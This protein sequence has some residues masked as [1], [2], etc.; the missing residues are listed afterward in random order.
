MTSSSSSSSFFFLPVHPAFG[1]SEPV[2]HCPPEGAGGDE[3][4]L[5]HGQ[6][7]EGLGRAFGV[8]GW[9]GG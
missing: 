9:V 3:E 7:R 2:A 1:A 5:G 8:G 6:H 4:D